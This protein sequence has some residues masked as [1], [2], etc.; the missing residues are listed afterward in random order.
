M[1]VLFATS[2]F[3]F[4]VCNVAIIFKSRLLASRR[5]FCDTA[6]FNLCS[7][8]LYAGNSH[9]LDLNL[10]IS[11]TVGNGPKENEGRLHF[12]SGPY[13]MHGGKSL[14]VT[15]ELN[16]SNFLVCFITLIILFFN[17][18]SNIDVLREH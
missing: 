18:L 6:L 3:L 15:F 10:G 7:S 14:R 1:K 12:H 13:N 11:P 2:C 16:Y 8:A 9:N 4:C 17:L 5:N